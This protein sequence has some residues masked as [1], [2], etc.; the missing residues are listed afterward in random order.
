MKKWPWLAAA[1]LVA[2]LAWTAAGPYRTVNAI[3]D[4]AQARD[5]QAMAEQVDFPALRSSLKAQLGDRLLR[6]VGTPSP[7]SPFAAFGLG[8]AG[9]LVDGL[10]DVLVTPAGLGAMMEGR[11]TWDR[12]TG[13]QSPSRDDTRDTTA[14]RPLHGAQYRFESPSRFTATVHDDQGRP[15]VFVM[16]RR[17]LDWKLSDIRLPPH[18]DQTTTSAAAP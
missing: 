1:G 5:A 13:R 3:R 15:V 16:T 12:A 2:L 7:D 4:A 14:Q 8:I 18:A 9:G 10:V 6:E 17:G 11:R